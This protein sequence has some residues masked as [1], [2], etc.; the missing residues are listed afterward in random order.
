MHTLISSYRELPRLVGATFLPVG[1]LARLP[2]SMTQLGTVLLV[3]TLTGS[4]AFAGL[5]AAALAIGSALGGP[6][7]GAR[8]DHSGQ[9]TVIVVAS[10]VNALLTVA[11]VVEV[12][13]TADRPV[14]L[15]TAAA[16]GVSTPPIGPLLRARWV[17]VTGGD[18]RLA[19][20]MSWEGAADEVSYVLGP[21]VVSLLAVISPTVAVLAAAALTAVFG[22]WVGLHRTSTRS[23]ATHA[24]ANLTEMPLRGAPAAGHTAK[25]WQHPVVARLILLA[26]A[27]GVF[28]GGMQTGVTAVAAA[29]GQLSSAGLLYSVMAVGSAVAGLASTALPASFTLSDRLPLFASWMAAAVIPLVLLAAGGSTSPPAAAVALLIL[30]AAVGPTLI[31]TYSM[32]EQQVGARRT[33]VTL[34]L[35]ASGTIVGYAIGSAVGGRLAQ[36]AGP[37]A[38]FAVSLTAMT[39]GAALAWRLRMTQRRATSHR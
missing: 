26:A 4:L 8:A 13:T 23:G 19:A 1:F 20:A 7:L 21:A 24:H 9:R 12:V 30:G 10:V 14:V 15:A 6:L 37:A 39:A 3:T 36:E 22:S 11:L 17:T 31:T 5:T 35:I 32:A 28:F 27:I 2:L 16:V 25:V 38:A 18:R 34:T 33:G 29:A